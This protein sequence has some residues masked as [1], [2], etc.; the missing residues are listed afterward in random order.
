VARYYNADMQ[1]AALAQPEF[2]LRDLRGVG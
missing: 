1:G 2:F